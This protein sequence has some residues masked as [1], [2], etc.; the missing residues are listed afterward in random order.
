MAVSYEIVA[1]VLVFAIRDTHCISMKVTHRRWFCIF[2]FGHILGKRWTVVIP[3]L[4]DY[5]RIG[6]QTYARDT[7]LKLKI[8][9]REK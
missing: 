7:E 1:Q 8:F 4:N 9:T 5:H 2:V 6:T 3:L